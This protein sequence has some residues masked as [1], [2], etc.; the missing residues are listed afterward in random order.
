MHRTRIKICGLT[1]IGDVQAACA[2]GADAVGFVCHP[3]SS[4][5]VEASRMAEL[6]RAL[7][8]FV[9]PVLL[10]V[11]ADPEEIRRRIGI[12]PDALLQFHGDEGHDTCRAFG[13][14]YL[15]AVAVAE[16]TDLLEF[17]RRF[18]TA[19]GLLADAP[20][21]GRGGAGRSF[22]WRR[23]PG[24]EARTMPLVLAGGLRA[25]NVAAA[26]SLARPYAVDVSSGVESAPGIK[27]PERIRRFIAAVRDGDS[28]AGVVDA[29]AG[30]PGTA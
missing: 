30:N 1:R 21:E 15:R 16:G 3:G 12:V 4:R 28:Q 5:F 20:S 24:P 27:D 9:T 25:E 13:R 19:A 26:I 10:F 18:P 17:E 14:P 7:A 8:P 6:A 22:D 11:N 29:G 23:L 2:L